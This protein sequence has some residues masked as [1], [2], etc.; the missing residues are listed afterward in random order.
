[1]ITKL[2]SPAGFKDPFEDESKFPK[3]DKKLEDGTF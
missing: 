2:E 1:M 3:A